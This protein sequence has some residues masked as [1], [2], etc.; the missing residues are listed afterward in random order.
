MKKIFTTVL[1]AALSAY[2]FAQVPPP[3]PCTPDLT[4]ADNGAIVPDTIVN[5]PPAYVD[6]VYS[7]VLQV[8]VPAET[9]VAPFGALPI[10]NFTLVSITGMPPEFTTA[11]NPG[12]SI[13]LGGTAACML[14]TTGT[15]V[16]SSA[17]GTY[18]LVV[19][20]IANVVS[21]FGPIG[22]P[23]A[24]SGYKIVISPAVAVI[25]RDINTFGI[26][27]NYPNPA[28]DNTTIEFGS[29]NTSSVALNVYNSVGTLVFS[30]KINATSG[31]NFTQI[32]TSALANGNY[33]YTLNNGT[34]VINGKF[35]VAK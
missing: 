30:N 4:N 14:L 35:S 9:I 2:G 27:G 19:N 16:V 26:L 3:G 11:T 31:S 15:N 32:S 20:V 8:F 25:T 17:P 21:P 23:A 7:T 13:F 1:F 28:T 10:T 33:I 12:D 18:P 34:N 29:A 5:L 24:L 6:A 22:Q